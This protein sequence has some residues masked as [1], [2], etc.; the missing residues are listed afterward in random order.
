MPEEPYS[1]REEVNALIVQWSAGRLTH[2]HEARLCSLVEC[3]VKTILARIPIPPSANVEREDLIQIGACAA[4]ECAP[5][6]DGEASDF[7]TF[8]F[9]RIRGAIYDHMRKVDPVPRSLR[10]ILGRVNK[11][12]R[13][14]AQK[15]GDEAG[16]IE[17][18]E[19]TG[20]PLEDVEQALAVGMTR[21]NISLNDVLDENDET[22]LGLRVQTDNDGV[23]EN[24]VHMEF[25]RAIARLPRRTSLVLYDVYVRDMPQRDVAT[26]HKLTEARISQIRQAGLDEVRSMLSLPAGRVLS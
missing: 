14:L 12:R 9:A 1:E 18:A 5:R 8:S 26:R 24:A 3:R 23:D 15:N 19:A 21:E 13:T 10:T 22:E 17:I 16:A 25:R 6:W 4:F 7:W 20:L 11:A 2:A